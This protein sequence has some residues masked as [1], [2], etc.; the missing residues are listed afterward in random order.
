MPG[1]AAISGLLFFAAA[2]RVSAQTC[3]I[4]AGTDFQAIDGFGFCTTWSPVMTSDQAA[5][6]FGTGNGQF[7][8]SLLRVY[9]DE[10]GDFTSDAANAAIAHSYGATVL[11]TAWTPPPA[12]K[13]NGS[14]VAGSLL[15]SQYAAYAAYLAGAAQA[16]GLDLVSFQNEPDIS[17]TYQ[18]CS[19]TPAQMETWMD[20]NAAAVGKPIV[21]P[22][23]YHFDD[24]YSDPTLDDPVGA[25]RIAYVAGHLYGG[26]NY[27]HTNA[28]S[29]DKHVWMTEHYNDGQDL[30][31][32]LVDAKEV[33]DCLDNQ[34]SAYIWWHA[35]HA[36]LTDLDL[37]NGSTPLLNGSA[38]GQ[39][40]HWLRPG[41][42][43]CSSTYNPQPGVY[44]TAFHHPGLVIVALNTGSAPVQQSFSVQN[45]TVDA[46]VPYQTG[47]PYSRQMTLLDPVAVS[48]N[49]FSFTLAPETVTTFVSYDASPPVIL[50]QPADEVV[51]PGSAFMLS[52]QAAGLGDS[53]QWYKDGAALPG[54][55]QPTLSVAA[56]SAADAGSYEAVITNALGSVTTRAAAI[57]VQSGAA[58]LINL[59]CRTQLSAGQ[60]T[61]AGFYIGGTGAKQVLIRAAGP[62]LAAFGVSDPLP[63]PQLTVYQG[64]TAIA[65]NA[66]WS[67]AAIGEGFQ[68]VGAFPFAPGSRDA[69]LLLTLDAG[70]GYTVQASSSGGNAGTVLVEVYDDDTGP[71]TAL[72]IN[73]SARASVGGSAANLTLGF[74]LGGA[75][76]RNV[77][78]RG[79]G[80][81]LAAFG[82]ADAIADP[83]LTLFDSNSQPLQAN[84]GWTTADSVSALSAAF[85]AVGAFAFAPGSADSALLSSLP[86]SLYSV[87]VTSAS[88]ATGEALA[89]IY[90]AP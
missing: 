28:L 7:G 41:M 69:A 43:R 85:T 47:G 6:L 4:D 2:L 65:Q 80:P 57:T 29:H 79:A 62:A 61:T 75:G 18:S 56:A 76:Q 14:S 70:Q 81:A 25:G 11:G 45:A 71:G 42:V 8:F 60:I 37:I 52:A 30:A 84:D 59:S 88:G 12:M 90:Q 17:V 26:G 31:T 22:E 10:T 20:N 9:I 73:L 5:Q 33:S 68:Q 67:P 1:F 53:F 21:M 15:T 51:F 50:T 72:L 86:P 27:V 89:E 82:V 83:Q 34:F 54:Q 63:D 13:D 23:S 44:V 77:L 19:W 78:I 87:Q 35:Y 3:L 55:T 39:F 36:T 40:A 48:G 24:A 49:A 32:A 58:R 74:V 64:S 66:A 46:L 16:I 38:L